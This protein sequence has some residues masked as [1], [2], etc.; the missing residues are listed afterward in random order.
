MSDNNAFSRRNTQCP[1]AAR[2]PAKTVTPPAIVNGMA[3]ADPQAQ[4]IGRPTHVDS[5][6]RVEFVRVGL[7]LVNEVPQSRADTMRGFRP[8]ML[9]PASM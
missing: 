2:H 9:G 5:V 8:R 7:M 3:T 1:G 4:R 6:W